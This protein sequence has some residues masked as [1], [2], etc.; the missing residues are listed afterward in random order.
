M[1]QIDNYFNESFGF[2]VLFVFIAGF[3]GDSLIHA[4]T[5]GQIP[6]IG[7]FAQ[8]LVPYYRTNGFIKSGIFGGLAC[9]IALIFGQLL[10]FAK[11]KD[12]TN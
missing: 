11:E 2:L 9:V 6:F 5:N 3:A 10:L 7:Q 12:E 4:G 1:K 8:S